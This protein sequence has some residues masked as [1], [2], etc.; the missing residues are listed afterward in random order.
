M[1]E[2]HASVLKNFGLDGRILK[3]KAYFICETPD[4]PKKIYKTSDSTGHI[5]FQHQIKEH[6][7]NAGYCWLD[8]YGLSVSG[9]P[10]V[11]F[12]G[13]NYV[14][15]P[16]IPG[17]ETDFTG[18]ADVARALEELARFHIC[19]RHVSFCET[20]ARLEG[21]SLDELFHRQS[22]DFSVIAKR[23]RKQPRL[24]DFDVL[25]IKN[26][27][28]YASQIQQ[29]ITVLKQSDYPALRLQALSQNQ[30]CHHGL[31]EESLILERNQVYITHFTDAAVDVQLNDV[32]MLLRRY[33]K[34][35]AR[36]TV[37]I[38]RALEAYSQ[39]EPLPGSAMAFLYAHL[40]FPWNFMKIVI[41]Y[42]SKKRSWTPN[43]LINRMVSV[44][45]EKEE[46][47]RYIS[48]LEREL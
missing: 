35:S 22:A 42:Y 5:L 33:A 13:E 46:Y 38:L 21:P 14:M 23:V 47:A 32:G 27:Q 40:L 29:A 48:E 16:F 39:T 8:R 10:F 15:T 9:Q 18:W 41:Q 19:A 44:V 17:R 43:A 4:G 7:Y 45:S 25:F 30:I 34:Q 1:G 24:S 2:L 36:H 11:V 28:F 12:G 6:V 26:Y 37:P 3:E 31:K 20:A